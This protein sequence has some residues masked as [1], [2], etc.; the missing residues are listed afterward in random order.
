MGPHRVVTAA[1]EGA[2]LLDVAIPVHVFDYE[3]DGRYRH[4]LVGTD[5]GSVRSSTGLPI[6]TQGGLGLLRNAN[7]IVVPGY[8]E[9]DRR[10]SEALLEALRSAARRGVRIVSI[11]TGAF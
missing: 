6:A 10:P 5:D 3:G 9:I 1:Q 11:C 7:T 2:V 4:R 8:I